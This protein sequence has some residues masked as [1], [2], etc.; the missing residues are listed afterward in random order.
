MAIWDS[1][2]SAGAEIFGGHQQARAMEQANETN[3]EIA[4]AQM[5]FQER[6]SS[7]AHQR[8]VDDLRKAGLNPILSASHGGASTPS[9]AS[10][11]VQPVN[12]LEGISRAVSSAY[13]TNKLSKEADAIDKD[14]DKKA[15]E[16]TVNEHMPDKLDA[17]AEKDRAD[18]RLS[19]K[20]TEVAEQMRK[21]ALVDTAR[22]EIA[23]EQDAALTSAV[24][25]QA[26]RDQKR[27]EYDS[28]WTKVDSWTERIG[29]VLGA[30]QSGAS[31]YRNYKGFK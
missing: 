9:G 4:N 26:L 19:E 11:T 10:T 24:K 12:K 27:A 30:G 1:L 14:I 23:K 2:I 3:R 22:A 29:K 13:Q 31:A 16:I 17:A 15:S 6:M 28:N 5:A 8:E 25:A 18:K 20:Q 7:T 21:K